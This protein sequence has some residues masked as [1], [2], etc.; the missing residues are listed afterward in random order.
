MLNEILNHRPKDSGSS[1]W[2]IGQGVETRYKGYLRVRGCSKINGL[3]GIVEFES[4]V[5]V[6][7][8]P[9]V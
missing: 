7:G 4:P 3:F 5:S 2:G 8:H 1:G 6:T 9:K